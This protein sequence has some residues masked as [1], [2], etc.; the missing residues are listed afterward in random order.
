MR[1]ALQAQAG[2]GAIEVRD[3]TPELRAGVHAGRPRR[4][5]GD[6]LG[7]DVN[8]AARIGESAKAGEVL[9]SETAC[10]HLDAESF[11]LGRSRRLRASGAPPGLGVRRVKAR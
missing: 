2:V 11:E 1:A 8:I 9:V 6:Y 7:V 3:H 4:V 5:G 10:D